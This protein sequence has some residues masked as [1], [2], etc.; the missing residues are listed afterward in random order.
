VEH[1]GATIESHLAY[2]FPAG[3]AQGNYIL[4]RIRLKKVNKQEENDNRK[5]SIN[6]YRPI[7]NF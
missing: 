3:F 1:D 7:S 5:P 6:K 2:R 4:K